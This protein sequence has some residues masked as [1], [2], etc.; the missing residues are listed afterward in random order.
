[1][2]SKTK[3][4]DDGLDAYKQRNF[5]D[6]AEI[7]TTLATQGNSEAQFNL[8]IMYKDGIGVPHN[9]VEAIKW[10]TKSSNQG[11]EHAGLIVSVLDEKSE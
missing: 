9:H 5:S 6:A 4:L 2:S 8:G 11:H 1:M 10:L 3:T 7:W